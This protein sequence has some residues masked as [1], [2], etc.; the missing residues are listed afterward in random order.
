M[1]N[2]LGLRFV[3][4]EIEIFEKPLNEKAFMNFPAVIPMEASRVPL[5]AELRIWSIALRFD[6]E[7]PSQALI[8]DLQ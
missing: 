8:R 4:L 1:V 2:W 3:L 6:T 7:L 5:L